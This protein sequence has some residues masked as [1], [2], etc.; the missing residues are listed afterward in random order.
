MKKH[1]IILVFAGALN[2]ALLNAVCNISFTQWQFWAMMIP[3]VLFTISVVKAED[4]D[5][6]K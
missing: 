1:D 4:Y 6:A 2:G 3:V 5:T